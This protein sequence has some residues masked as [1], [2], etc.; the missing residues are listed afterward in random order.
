MTRSIWPVLC[1]ASKITIN[2]LDLK[3]KVQNVRTMNSVNMYLYALLWTIPFNMGGYVT[4]IFMIWE[5]ISRLMCF[6]PK[7]PDFLLKLSGILDP[8]MPPFR[9][10][11]ALAHTKGCCKKTSR[12]DILLLSAKSVQSVLKIAKLSPS[13]TQLSWTE[14]S[15]IFSLSS[16][17]PTYPAGHLADHPPIQNSSE[18]SESKTLIAG[19]SLY[20]V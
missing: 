15:L 4:I 12:F 3:F 5:K 13:S 20:K 11:G 6:Q 17:P 7:C 10:S 9:R 19:L 18:I 2:V 14:F 1:R 16:H 8:R